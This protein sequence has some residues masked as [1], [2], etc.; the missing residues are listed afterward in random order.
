MSETSVT[1]GE[2]VDTALQ[3]KIRQEGDDVEIDPFEASRI[4]E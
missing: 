3:A 1:G 2:E 4:I